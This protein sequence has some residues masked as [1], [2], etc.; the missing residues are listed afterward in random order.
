[1]S[2]GGRTADATVSVRDRETLADYS[3]DWGLA[4]TDLLIATTPWRRFRWHRGQKH[5][6]GTYW[7][8][9]ER[10]HVIYE[11]RLELARLLYADLDAAVHR[12]VAQPFL[13]K[14]KIDRRVRRHVPDFLLIDEQGPV[15]VDVK[16]LAQLSNPKVSLT[17]DWTRKLVEN[18]GWRYE[19]WNEPPAT[20]LGNIRFLAGFRNPRRFDDSLVEAIRQQ[21]L[22]GRTL[23]DALSL[24]F[25]TPP[26]LTRSAVF[27]VIWS[28]YLTVDMAEP[29]TRSAILTKGPRA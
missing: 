20:E 12:I 1:M 2:G 23:G 26:A 11:S 5:Y 28:Q 10:S 22:I 19:V 21:E 8:S 15:V 24:D 18:R 14:T 25:G 16:P 9:T 4:T 17:L 6:S 7:S 29:L 13:L 27:H 3:T